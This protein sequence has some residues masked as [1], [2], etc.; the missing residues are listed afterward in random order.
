MI[1]EK[2]KTVIMKL[3]SSG[4][5]IPRNFLFVFLGPRIMC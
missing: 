3:S 2:K 5:Y 4:A 1:L